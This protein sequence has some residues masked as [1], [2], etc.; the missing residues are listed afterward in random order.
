VR[1]ILDIPP[2]LVEKINE[3]LRSKKYNSLHDFLTA[4][5]QNQVYYES[6]EDESGHEVP[7]MT[8]SSTTT[9]SVVNAIHLLQLSPRL[10]EVKV[11]PMS[12]LP[13]HDYLWGQYNRLFPVKIV[14][15]VASNLLRIS[16]SEQIPL[17]ELQEKSAEIARDLGKD[18]ARKERSM[19]RKRGEIISAALP[20]GRKQDKTESR[21]KNQ[22]VG[23]VAKIKVEGEHTPAFRVEGA[24]PTLKFLSFSLDEKNTVNVGITDPGLKF[25]ILPNPVIELQNYSAPFSPEEIEFLLEHIASEIPR[26]A[27]LI[28]L[29]LSGVNEGIATPEGLNERMKSFKKENG[30]EWKGNEAITMRVGV[31]SRVSE[32]G[33]LGRKKD[34]VRVT[35]ELT[36]LGE[37]YLERLNKLEV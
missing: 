18:I 24:A 37:K 19:G 25:S 6:R 20:I 22:F 27:M 17:L 4:A 16:G 7:V 13:R 14:T 32:L 9:A 21:F 1:Y 12:D 23:Y 29:I 5:I 10:S 26:E 28:R 35:Y 15:R 36:D 3:Y 8:S 2:E 31:V 30:R 11:V 34:G 33:L